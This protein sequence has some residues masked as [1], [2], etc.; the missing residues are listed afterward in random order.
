MM[1]LGGRKCHFDIAF[2]NTSSPRADGDVARAIHRVRPKFDS[3]V[4]NSILRAENF[5]E[6]FICC[7]KASFLV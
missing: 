1:S 7:V 6:P 2:D 3:K 4:A 5:A